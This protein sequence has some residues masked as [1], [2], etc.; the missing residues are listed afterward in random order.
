[1]RLASVEASPL[2]GGK[3]DYEAALARCIGR[4]MLLAAIGLLV[5]A[6]GLW[7]LVAWLAAGSLLAA[8]VA[9]AAWLGVAFASGQALARRLARAMAAPVNV[10]ASGNTLPSGARSRKP[11]PG[12]ARQLG[13]LRKLE[14]HLQALAQAEGE[15]IAAYDDVIA[16]LVR[17][18]EQAQSANVA[19][20]QFLANMSHE[21]RT[22]LNAII[23]YATLLQE[24]ARAIDD[25]AAD[26]DLTRILEAS[27]RLLELIN[28]VLD[29]SALEARKGEFQRTI[30]DVRAV[31]ESVAA[32]FGDGE[33]TGV[34]FEVEIAADIGIVIGDASKIR[35]CL[36]NLLSN[37]FK[38][39][40]AGKVTL[41]AFPASLSDGVEGVGF[42]VA[43]T[44][45]GM[46]AA[47]LENL[48]EPFSQ[49]DASDARRHA[50]SGVGLAVTRRITRMMGGEISVESR[51]G[52]G[53]VFT[54]ILPREEAAGAL[55]PAS[56]VPDVEPVA[57]VGDGKLA[58]LIDDDPTALN[59][60]RRRLPQHGY[61]IIS[62]TDGEAGLALALSEGPDLIFLDIK[63]PGMDGYQVLERLRAEPTL[64]ETP[65]I[66]VTVDNDR[67]RALHAGATEHLMKPI[68]NDDLARVL[69]TY[70]DDMVGEVLVIDDDADAGDLIARTAAQI[71]LRSRRAY[72]G[73]EGLRMIREQ[74]P[75]VVVLDLTL[76]KLDGFEVLNALQRDEALTSLPVLV[77]S[78]RP[79]TNPEHAAI[80]KAGCTY[81][82]KGEYSPRQIAQLLKGAIAA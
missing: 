26:A 54:L 70:R 61:A 18:K 10:I 13:S 66:V 81:L 77:F 24:D 25:H 40:S 39:T 2:A 29:L 68:S 57:P 49:A 8:L 32:S 4:S 76:P 50:G 30:V 11:A 51:E 69:A 48:F 21:L 47:R 34:A 36:L 37:A 12:E 46:S 65:V 14:E 52:E 82:T 80:R 75:S 60:M 55:L 72:D 53:S 56:P 1:M 6:A 22:P 73:V 35:Q 19:K 67:R 41:K 62:A 44:G 23:G 74:A 20:S 16:E 64:A 28:D 3:H 27:A 5:A 59:L 58:L 17:L 63:M 9:A 78:G 31:I 45:I 71:G 42:A 79:I 43:D 7:L 38:F 33:R 15:R